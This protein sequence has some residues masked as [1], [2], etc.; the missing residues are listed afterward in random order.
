MRVNGKLRMPTEFDHSRQADCVQAC[1]DAGAAKSKYQIVATSH[2]I[3]LAG[4]VECEHRF[5]PGGVGMCVDDCH[6]CACAILERAS[7]AVRLKLIVFDEVNTGFAKRADN[8]GGLRCS[9]ADAGLDDCSNQRS[10]GNT[11]QAARAFY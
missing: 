1:H 6:D 11:R 3:H 8:L 5:S 7:G 4:K 9:K 2:L 10:P